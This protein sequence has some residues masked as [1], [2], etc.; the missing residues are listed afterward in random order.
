MLKELERIALDILRFYY[1]LVFFVYPFAVS[2]SH[3]IATV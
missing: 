2:C 1:M 3:E